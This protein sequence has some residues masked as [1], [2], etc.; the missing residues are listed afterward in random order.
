MEKPLGFRFD[1][2]KDEALQ[3]PLWKYAIDVFGQSAEQ[4]ARRLEKDTQKACLDRALKER[5]RCLFCDALCKQ[6][7]HVRKRVDETYMYRRVYLA[8]QGRL[9]ERG[10][11]EVR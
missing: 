1:E 9:G 8:L 4:G 3:S 5:W 6:T 7:I 2:V 10:W 11:A